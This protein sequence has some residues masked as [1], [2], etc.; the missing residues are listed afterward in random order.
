MKG[1]IMGAESVRAILDGRKTRHSFPVKPQ[2]QEHSEVEIGMWSP[3]GIDKHGMAYPK[4]EVWGMSFESFG[5]G[6]IGVCPHYKVGEIVY[7]KETWKVAENV[8]VNSVAPVLYKAECN[9]FALANIDNWKSPLFMPEWAS[10]IHLEITDIKAHRVQDIT[11][12]EAMAE[13]IRPMYTI[14]PGECTGLTND[15]V[16]EYADLWDSLNAKRGYPWESNPWVFAYTFKVVEG[17][18]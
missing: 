15:A 16:D 18:V 9:S 17:K 12:E 4:P 14:L 5:F 8:T 10:R 7:V 2:P 3:T 6:H 13:G 11:E 1:I